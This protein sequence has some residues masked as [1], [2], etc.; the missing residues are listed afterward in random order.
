MELS[1]Q[2]TQGA[3]LL[4]VDLVGER[5]GLRN[6]IDRAVLRSPG[7]RLVAKRRRRGRGRRLG[8]EI[9]VDGRGAPHAAVA[10]AVAGGGE[11]ARGRVPGRDAHHSTPAAR[12]TAGRRRAPREQPVE[13]SR[14]LTC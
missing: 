14:A 5:I 12:A 11:E 13:E 6:V 4:F 10:A 2:V 3:E 9:Q 1:G 8:A 7:G